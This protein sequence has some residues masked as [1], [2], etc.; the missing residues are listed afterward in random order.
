[1]KN[2]ALSLENQV[3]KPLARYGRSR[4]LHVLLAVS[5]GVDSMVM[6]EILWRWRRYLGW[7]LSVA[8]VHHGSGGS[9]TQ[10]AF[11]IQARTQVEEFCRERGLRLF[12]NPVSEAELNSEQDMRDYRR[13]WLKAW[14]AEG[15]FDHVA[16]AHHRDDLLETR[17]LRLIRGTGAQGLRGM[18]RR[19]PGRLLRPLLGL[20]R[21]QVLD[22][23]RLRCLTWVE[24]PSNQDLEPLRNWLRREWLPALDRRQ[25]GARHALARS[26]ETL[27]PVRL[28]LEFGTY[29]GL[30]RT[31]LKKT[32]PA[33]Q[34]E[35]VA[36]YLR[37]LG[38]QGYGRT[39]VDELLK[40]LDTLQKN[41]EFEML[42]MTFQANSDFLWASRV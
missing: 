25:N 42:G 14:L 29:V 2:R 37:S 1:M 33:N 13:L 39:H 20:S 26:L 41:F 17:L 12:T 22:Y 7:N 4:P 34:R 11:R 18:T 19:G 9:S 30:R 6:A 35:I 36:R 23:A 38:M 27:A 21:E 40:R 10:K 31:S 32:S 28:P 3:L 5:G 16:L 8:H 15:K 24:D